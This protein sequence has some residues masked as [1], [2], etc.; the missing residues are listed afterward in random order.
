MGFLMAR[1]M[2]VP[3]ARVIAVPLARAMTVLPRKELSGSTLWP[4]MVAILV[5]VIPTQPQADL[6][7]RSNC[8]L[9]KT[10]YLDL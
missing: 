9:Q 1:V 7:G 8:C 2:A 4:T 6:L 5:G 10:T 3:L